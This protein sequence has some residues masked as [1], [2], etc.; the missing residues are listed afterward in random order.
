MKTREASLTCLS[1]KL[2]CCTFRIKKLMVML[3]HT[4]SLTHSLSLSLYH[5]WIQTMP[6]E[7]DVAP[8][9]LSGV[10]SH[11]RST[12]SLYQ[13]TQFKNYTYKYKTPQ[14]QK[15]KKITPFMLLTI[16]KD[17]NKNK[18]IPAKKG[19]KIL[20]KHRN[21]NL[22]TRKEKECVCVCARLC[23]LIFSLLCVL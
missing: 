11:T 4:H 7:S 14:P 13:T 9:T 12:S 20:K 21:K 23:V 5:R 1:I 19:E 8:T 15:P 16:Q 22:S 17:T 18:S 2:C 3:S 6:T 10:N